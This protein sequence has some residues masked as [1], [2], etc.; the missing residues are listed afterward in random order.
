M[1]H[2]LKIISKRST[3]I[4]LKE[5]GEFI[6]G[7]AFNLQFLEDP[8]LENVIFVGFTATKK[9]GKSV[10]RNKAKRIMRELARKVIAKYGKTNSYYVLIAKP[11]I[12]E[13]SFESQKNELIKLIS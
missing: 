8:N 9:L 3:F 13:I 4:L 10:K 2:S 6:S 11:S 12:F 5:K 7:K 1:A